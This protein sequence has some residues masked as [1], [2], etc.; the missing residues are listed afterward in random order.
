V[1]DYHRRCGC[2]CVS[3]E[4]FS[5]KHYVEDNEMNYL[6]SLTMAMENYFLNIF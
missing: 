3:I 2:A 4:V 1:F 6:K 5:N